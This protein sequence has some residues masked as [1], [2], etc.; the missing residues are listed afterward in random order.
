M[1]SDNVIENK[2]RDTEFDN[3]ILNLCR[4][5]S[6]ILCD[7]IKPDPFD[8]NLY[9]SIIKIQNYSG[10][11]PDKIKRQKELNEKDEI[12][13]GDEIKGNKYLKYIELEQISNVHGRAGFAFGPNIL[14]QNALCTRG[15]GS[16][17][18]LSNRNHRW[19]PLVA[20]KSY[21]KGFK[22]IEKI[23]TDEEF[24]FK[25][26]GKERVPKKSK[27][28]IF[29]IKQNNEIKKFKSSETFNIKG[30]FIVLPENWRDLNSELAKWS[31]EEWEFAKCLI[32]IT[33]ACDWFHAVESFCILGIIKAVKIYGS[34]FEILKEKIIQKLQSQNIDENI[35]L[36]TQSFNE[37]IKDPDLFKCPICKKDI[38][39]NLKEFRD[40]N[41]GETWKPQWVQD[42]SEEGDDDSLQF[43]HIKPLVEHEVRNTAKNSAYGHRWCNI[44][45][46]DHTVEESLKL[47][48]HVVKVHDES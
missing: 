20:S 40:N 33:E 18:P 3:S 39:E 31:K 1:S 35:E 6:K 23:S 7:S 14:Q 16:K 28:L 12:F 48:R 24:F 44:A 4:S 43:L 47:F 36:P 8:T 46:T 30:K 29:H 21:I 37:R 5:I 2:V 15:K 38:N 22:K 17:N 10:K 11:H 25:G 41:R 26:R 27:T 42:K 9:N 34:N 19:H 32:P 13:Q 45:M